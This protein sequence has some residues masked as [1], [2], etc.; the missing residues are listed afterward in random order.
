LKLWIA[1]STALL[2]S[3]VSSMTRF[4]RELRMT[5]A[6]SPAGEL[7]TRGAS[8]HRLEGPR[9]R[10]TSR[11]FYVPS[12][13][14]SSTPTQRIVEVAAMVPAD[15]VMG[16]WAAAYALGT[17]QLDG[18]DDYTLKPI[19]VPV[20]LPPG[21]H[22]K[23]VPGVHYLQQRLDAA[24]VVTVLGLRFS[25][26]VRTALDLSRAARNL[27]EAVVALDLM[28]QAKVITADDLTARMSDFAGRPGIGQAAR[29]VQLC[30]KGV[31]SGWESRMRMLYVLDLG[32]ASPKVNV[33]V[34]S[35]A[36]QFLGAPD[37]LDVEAGL[38]MEYDGGTWTRGTTPHGHRDPDRHRED[39]AREELLERARL[40]V[41]RADKGDLTRFRRRLQMRLLTAR[42]EGLSRDRSRDGWTLT[43]PDGWYGMP[44]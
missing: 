32:F 5:V 43:A 38:A 44:A 42:A 29:A 6:P 39:N 13:G 11:G 4:L 23:P 14:I 27:T 37:M 40:I 2:T 31:L 3:T 36:G 17:D 34:F 10:R 24:D 33:P 1:G 41:V 16:G 18:R 7:L 8:K 20:F 19:A 35:L 12:S 25:G 22:R 9:W 21:L 30:R 28:L 15:A 26:P